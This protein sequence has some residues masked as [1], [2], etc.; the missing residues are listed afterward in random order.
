MRAHTM[1]SSVL[2]RGFDTFAKP[3]FAALLRSVFSS[4]APTLQ[5]RSFSAFFAAF[6][7]ALLLSGEP[8][9]RARG[10]C[11][12]THFRCSL[13]FLP[14]Y[15]D[16]SR[17]RA[18]LHLLLHAVELH[19]V[20]DRHRDHGHRDRQGGGVVRLVARE[21]QVVRVH[22]RR[23]VRI[24]S[25]VAP[26]PC[27]AQNARLLNSWNEPMIEKITVIASLFQF[28]QLDGLDDLPL[29][30]SRRSRRPRTANAGSWTAG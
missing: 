25:D 27:S 11:C 10:D 21:A 3:D 30:R 14:L 20:R 6:S 4:R 29:G 1:V 19:R 5:E 22:V 26:A 15:A 28:R 16:G 23:V 7:W 12:V 17:H 13:A 2:L 24:G 8:L 9:L 18:L